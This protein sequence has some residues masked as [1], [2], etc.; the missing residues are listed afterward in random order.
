MDADK[1]VTATFACV[2]GDGLSGTC[3][4][5]PSGCTATTCG[6]ASVCRCPGS[7]CPE[8]WAKK[9]NCTQTQARSCSGDTDGC[10]RRSYSNR[11][12]TGSHTFANTEPESCL[13]EHRDRNLWDCR[14]WTRTCRATVTEVGCF[15]T[16]FALPDLPFLDSPRPGSD[17]ERGYL[18]APFQ[19]GSEPDTCRVEIDDEVLVGAEGVVDRD[20]T[21]EEHR[22]ACRSDT[23]EVRE[24]KKAK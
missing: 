6:G 24:C 16:G 11:C 4:G 8:L 13:Y 23:G 15:Y 14:H 21:D 12:T 2:F 22:W 7:S 1:S 5:C 3:I 20:D 18:L 10:G 17:Y 19:C 9:D